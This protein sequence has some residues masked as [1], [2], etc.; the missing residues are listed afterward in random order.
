M[1]WHRVSE[2]LLFSTRGPG[3]S[4]GSQ[5]SLSFPPCLAPL[6]G[7]LPLQHVFSQSS[8]DVPSALLSSSAIASFSSVA[9]EGGSGLSLASTPSEATEEFESVTHPPISPL[10]HYQV[11]DLLHVDT[12]H[13]LLNRN[14]IYND[15]GG[16]KKSKHLDEGDNLTALEREILKF[17]SEQIERKTN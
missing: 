1:V 17:I 5:Q 14:Q 7:I 9:E 16:S 8:S 6:P 15:E 3:E 10:K 11:S 4:G 2:S 13:S 12:A